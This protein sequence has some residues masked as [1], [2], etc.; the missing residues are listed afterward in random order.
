MASGIAPGRQ[1]LP[2]PLLGRFLDAAKLCMA[3]DVV[4]TR[5][6]LKQGEPVGKWR[7]ILLVRTH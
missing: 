4:A 6:P 1:Q 5:R 7:K 3:K 2:Q